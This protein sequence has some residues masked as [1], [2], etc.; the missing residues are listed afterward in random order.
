MKIGIPVKCQNGHAATWVV[1]FR[2]L[3]AVSLGVDHVGKCACPK[4]DIGQGYFRDGEPFVLGQADAAR[5]VLAEI[6]RIDRQAGKE[7]AP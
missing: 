1:E 2:G 3:D 7:V 5:D 4:H 6:E